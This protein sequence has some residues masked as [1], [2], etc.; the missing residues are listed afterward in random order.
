MNTIRSKCF[1]LFIGSAGLIMAGTPALADGSDSGNS[2]ND[3]PPQTTQYASSSILSPQNVQ[4]GRT[5]ADWAAAWWQWCLSIPHATH[6]LFTSGNVDASIGQTGPVWFLGGNFAGGPGPLVRNCTIPAGKALFF[7]VVNYEDSEVEETL[8]YGNPGTTINDLRA[9]VE[10]AINEA[11]ANNTLLLKIDGSAV[12]NL[13]TTY[14]VRSPAFSYTLPDDNIWSFFYG[15]PF[16]AGT[17]NAAIDDGIYVML[18]P[19]NRG[20]HVI[21][22]HA[23]IPSLGGFVVDVT[24]NI[25]VTP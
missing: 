11:A 17:Y 2:Y 5:Y 19:L 24:Y 10:P 25:T 9:I 6:P 4:Y 20:R 23:E 18:A 21:H 12:R 14:R 13:G 8:G 15:V 1:S 7:P 22:F 3:L 16:T